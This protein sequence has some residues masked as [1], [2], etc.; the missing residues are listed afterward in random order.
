MITGLQLQAALR[1]W[2]FASVL[3]AASSVLARHYISIFE[4][5]AK[6][7]RGA[8]TRVQTLIAAA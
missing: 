7:R 3:H 1:F 2:P 8:A 6:P 5:H 4:P